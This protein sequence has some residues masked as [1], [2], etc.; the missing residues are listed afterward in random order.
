MLQGMDGHRS[1][2]GVRYWGHLGALEHIGHECHAQNSKKAIPVAFGK[3]QKGRLSRAT[4][5]RVA[6]LG[7]SIPG[8]H[9]VARTATV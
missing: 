7:H 2:E 3:L 9:S 1:R 6:E 8:I 4:D 5:A